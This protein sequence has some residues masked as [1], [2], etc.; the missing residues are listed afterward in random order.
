MPNA[1]TY[2]G[3]SAGHPPGACRSPDAVAKWAERSASKDRIVTPEDRAR[4][5][6]TAKLKRYGLTPET[7]DRMLEAQGYA[8]AMCQEPFGEN[9]LIFIDHDHTLGCHP[10]EKQ[11]CD[12]CRRG[13]V[14]LRCNIAV[15]YIERY[16]ELARA[17]LD[18]YAE[19]PQ[20]LVAFA[21]TGR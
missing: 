20:P 12:R 15:G 2:C 6:Q 13:L 10:G 4:W 8:C 7:F 18:R 16:E 1:K 19:Y 5:H 14:N 9:E 17:Y 21:G 3:R 11:A